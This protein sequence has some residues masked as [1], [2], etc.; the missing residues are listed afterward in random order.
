MCAFIYL[1]I[2]STFFVLCLHLSV[3]A[4]GASVPRRQGCVDALLGEGLGGG[5]G[6]LR[7]RRTV[8]QECHGA[9]PGK[10]GEA[11]DPFM[12]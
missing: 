1:F 5:G 3:V 2:F 12:A 7:Q 9:R 4:A 8:L 11:I 6:A 10:G